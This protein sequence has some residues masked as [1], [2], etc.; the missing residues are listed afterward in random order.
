MRKQDKTKKIGALIMVNFGTQLAIDFAAI[1][2][3]TEVRNEKPEPDIFLCAAERIS[4]YD[5]SK[6]KGLGIMQLPSK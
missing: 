3:G 1:V 5:A 4:S 2:S 6:G